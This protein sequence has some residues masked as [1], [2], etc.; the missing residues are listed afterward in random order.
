M[1]ITVDTTDED[2]KAAIV[3]LLNDVADSEH[4]LRHRAAFATVLEAFG[5]EL[6][7]EGGY[8]VVDPVAEAKANAEREE[9]EKKR[10]ADRGPDIP[11]SPAPK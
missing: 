7:H 4:H 8:A 6:R 9:A 3:R 10:I 1:P 2:R 5:L 11:D